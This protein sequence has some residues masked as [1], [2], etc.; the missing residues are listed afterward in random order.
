MR[1]KAPRESSKPSWLMSSSL[2]LK[3]VLPRL[4]TRTF[5]SSRSLSLPGRGS[6]SVS[7]EQ[8]RMRARDH[9]RRD[10]LTDAACRFGA[11]VDG[12]F[13]RADVAADDRGHERS[14]DLDR[15]DDLD[16]GG[17]AHRVG[18]LDQADPALGLD[19]AERAAERTVAVA[20]VAC[21]V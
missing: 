19:H 5:M 18:G 4:A 7:G 3:L 14:A 21:H 17:L 2:N 20:V 15:L 1:S 16:V 6:S 11:G 12:G 8:L 10:Q 9:V 13:H